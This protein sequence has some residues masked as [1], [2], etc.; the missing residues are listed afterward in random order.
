M[1]NAYTYKIE[2]LDIPNGTMVVKYTP[3]DTSLTSISYNIPV[4]FNED[5]TQKPLMDNIDHYAPNREW[6]AQKF[7]KENAEAL[8]NSTGTVNP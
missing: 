7:L 4:L 2:Q 1:K 8:I 3:S 6:N 5:G